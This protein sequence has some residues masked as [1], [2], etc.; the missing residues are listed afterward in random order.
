MVGP[1]SKEQVNLAEKAQHGRNASQRQQAEAQP[2]G[3]QGIFLIE[4][5]VIGD[6]IT[7]GAQRKQD[8]AGK[9]PQV[10]EQVGRHVQDHGGKAIGGA[11]HQA[12]HHKASLAN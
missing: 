6:A 5:G 1:A 2:Q 3:D 9:G 7:A 8:D 12:N 11:A 10:H 4:T